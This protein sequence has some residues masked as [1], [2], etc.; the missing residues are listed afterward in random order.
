[1]FLAAFTAIAFLAMISDNVLLAIIALLGGAFTGVVAPV[2]LYV[3]KDRSETRIRREEREERLE[4]ARLTKESLDAVKLEGGA[5]EK[6]ITDEVKKVKEVAIAG[7]RS[8]KDAFK[9]ANNVNIKIANLGQKLVDD[10]ATPQPVEIMNGPE[11][12]V[13]T[14]EL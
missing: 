9:E 1:M 6:R 5:R 4:L 10:K 2:V 11:H 3:L 7:V 14:H 12:P 8:A 13:P